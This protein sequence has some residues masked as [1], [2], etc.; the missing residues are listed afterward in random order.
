[1]NVRAA[2]RRKCSGR[3]ARTSLLYSSSTQLEKQS[4][5]VYLLI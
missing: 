5:K 4:S 1:M 2:F 3:L